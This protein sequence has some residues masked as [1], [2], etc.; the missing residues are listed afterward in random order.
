MVYLQGPQQCW[1]S[2]GP[3]YLGRCMEV[4]M[5]APADGS[6]W[7]HIYQGTASAYIHTHLLLNSTT[8]LCCLTFADPHGL[9][10][11]FWHDR[12]QQVFPHPAPQHRAHPTINRQARQSD[13]PAEVPAS[14]VQAAHIQHQHRVQQ[15]QCAGRRGAF[16]GPRTAGVEAPHN[17]TGTSWAMR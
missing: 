14:A 2:S 1:A 12:Q 8:C 7:S 13:T 17:V 15:Q 11:D 3:A 9:G 16:R 6:L 4:S 10:H 5:Q